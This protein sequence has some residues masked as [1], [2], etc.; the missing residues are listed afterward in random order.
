M[1]DTEERV[2]GPN[3]DL[4]AMEYYWQTHERVEGHVIR[5]VDALR[6]MG[7]SWADIASRT[8]MTR[9]GLQNWRRS[10]AQAGL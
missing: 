3:F 6:E 5:V 10:R 8:N 2:Y 4:D 7:Y 1:T 9:Q